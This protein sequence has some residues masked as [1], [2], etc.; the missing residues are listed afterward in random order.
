M[1]ERALTAL[2]EP[3]PPLPDPVGPG[4]SA[5][6]P[7]AGTRPAPHTPRNTTRDSWQ[8]MWKDLLVRIV[9]FAVASG[10]Y[11]RSLRRQGIRASDASGVSRDVAR[12]LA[13][14]IPLALM[15]AIFRGWVAPGY[16]LPTPADQSLQTT[17]YFAINAPAEELF[18]R[19][20]VQPLIFCGGTLG[21]PR[22]RG[23]WARWR[24]ARRLG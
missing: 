12:G 18:W 13:W 19:G 6:P 20:T 5:S 8:W 3:Q 11:A 9:P 16:R 4:H 15:S 21:G 10:L 7:G 24:A 1:K 17:Y 23:A 2:Q 14:G 22:T